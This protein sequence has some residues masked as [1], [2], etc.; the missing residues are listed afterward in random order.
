M[1]VSHEP[2]QKTEATTGREGRV[3]SFVGLGSSHPATP[4]FFRDAWVHLKPI[5]TNRG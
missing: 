1:E 3:D 5:L 2:I 4:H